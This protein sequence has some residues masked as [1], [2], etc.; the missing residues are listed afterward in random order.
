MPA[1]ETFRREMGHC[2]VDEDFEVPAACPWPQE[3]WGLPLG[4]VVRDVREGR[5]YA[6]QVAR[7]KDEL[8]VLRF[9]WV[10]EAAVWDD[11]ILPA[12]EAFAAEVGHCRVPFMFVVPSKDPWPRSAWGMNLGTVV[13][14]MRGM[15]SF[16]SYV[17]RDADRLEELGYSLELSTRVWNKCVAPLL[18]VYA[19]LF[20]QD[21]PV[22]DG[23]IAPREY[24][25]PEEM[26]GV[27][28]GTIVARNSRLVPRMNGC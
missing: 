5:V 23:F 15:G 21:V 19:T 12:I 9:P 27:R 22:S 28:L 6:D 17:G 14:S 16:F 26:W 20:G 18:E 7:D 3:T 24:P 4:R 2:A 10:H 1:L 25:W 8:G 11:R 13:A